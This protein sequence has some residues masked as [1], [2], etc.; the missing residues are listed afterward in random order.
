MVEYSRRETLPFTNQK[1][2]VVE[3]ATL[4]AKGSASR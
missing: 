2:S 3:L 1:E 4:K